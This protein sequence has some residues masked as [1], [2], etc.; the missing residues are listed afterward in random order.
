MSLDDHCAICHEQR[1]PLRT[2]GFG[3][4]HYQCLLRLCD[5]CEMVH[6]VDHEDHCADCGENVNMCRCEREDGP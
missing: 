5:A 6:E 1:I 4:T 3:G 2:C